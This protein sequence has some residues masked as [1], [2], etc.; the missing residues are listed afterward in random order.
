[1]KKRFI[2][3]VISAVIFSSC[4]AG[5]NN[6]Q[7]NSESDNNEQLPHVEESNNDGGNQEDHTEDGQLNGK[8]S[9]DWEVETVANNLDVPWSVMVQED[10]FYMS[11]RNGSIVVVNGSEMER[12]ELMTSDPIAHEGEAGLLGFVLA[13]DYED[14]REGIAYYTF[15]NEQ[16]NLMNRVV[17]IEND[18]GWE[19]TEILLDEIPG[20]RIHNGGRLAIGPDNMLYVTTGDANIPEDSQ[21]ETNLAGSILR[22]THKG[23]VPEDNPLEGSYVYSYG[24]RNPQGLAWNSEGNLYSSE[25]GPAAQD[26]LNLIEPGKNYGWPVIEGDESADD[27]EEPIIHS[28]ED[29]WA[30]SG[31][32]FWTDHLLMTGLRGESL[33]YY[34]EEE[35]NIVQIFE[36]KGRL[37]DVKVEGNSI[38][39]IT[40]NTDGRGSPD[41]DDDKLLKLTLND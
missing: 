8:T 19:E 40:N 32:A 29:T 13:D 16:G 21:D 17:K 7:T 18:D 24:H 2:V 27:M 25:H 23:E 4:Q 39:I 36:G 26:E 38:Y 6:D 33:Y 41:E 14:S 11:E 1:M 20:D 28:G 15:V 30:P 37:R 31:I 35:N 10:A 12:Q 22:M 34:H 9:E 5:E 3:L